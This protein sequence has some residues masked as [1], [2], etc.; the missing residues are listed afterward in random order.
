MNIEEFFELFEQE[1]KQNK[2]LTSYHRF[3]NEASLYNFRKSYLE[4]RYAYVVKNIPKSHSLIWDVGCGY[5]TTCFL[6]ASMGHKVI[7][8]TLEYYFEQIDTRL[9]FWSK[10]IDISNIDFEYNTIFDTNYPKEYFDY[11]LAIDTLHHIEPFSESVQLFHNAL[12]PKGSIIIC[13]ENG[14]N[15]INRAKN[16]KTRGCK[17]ITTMYDPRLQKEILFGNENTRSLKQW[18]REFSVAPFVLD[19]D[20]IEYIRMFLPHYYKGKNT[21]QIIEQEQALWKKYAFLKEYFFFGLNFTV[22]K[23]I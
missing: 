10:Y 16:F 19:K 13:E 3:T 11:I 6:L 2:A 9:E 23:K 18:Q 5:G 12:K 4:Q 17:R 1:L 21:S 20:S 22:S 15:I 8:T 14:N 7:G